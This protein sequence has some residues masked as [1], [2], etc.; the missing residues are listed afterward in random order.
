VLILRRRTFVIN[1]TLQFSIMLTS[2]G[3]VGFL[4]LVM[5]TAL[6]APLVLQLRRPGLNSTEASD[7]ALRIL[8]LHD[9]YWLPVV[10]TLVAIAL[11]SVATSHRIA[12]P[13]FR[14]RRVCDAMSAG[15]I[16]N[17]VVLRKHDRLRP[18]LDAVNGML[19]A[20]RALIADA[21]RKAGALHESLDTYGRLTAGGQGDPAA[22]AAWADVVRTHQHLR[23]TLGRVTFEGSPDDARAPGHSTP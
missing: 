16:P 23:D 17:R 1:R 19:D 7:A 5:S 18:E 8:Y 12:G 21:Q 4:V 20:W 15:V 6:F 10:L 11:H 9:T 2:L 13:I 3:Y 14:F 22:G